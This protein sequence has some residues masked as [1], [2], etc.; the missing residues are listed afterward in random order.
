[1]PRTRFIP[2]QHGF[3]FRND[4]VNTILK[5]PRLETYGLCGGMALAALR[6]Y[7]NR[8]SVPT[9]TG[10]DFGGG[11]TVP[12]EGS[13]LRQFIYDNQMISY[14]PFNL[15]SAANWVTLPG[16]TFDTQ[17]GWSL[18]DEFP[19]IKQQLDATQQPI[20]LGLRGRREGDPFG[21]Q[22]L[23]IG[24]DENP[25]RVYLYD[26]NYPDVEMMICLDEARRRLV[27][28]RSDGSGANADLYASLFITGCPVPAE[29]PTY[30]DLGLQEGLTL[31]TASATPRVG[32]RLEVEVLVRNYGDYPA[33]V[34]Q[35]YVYVRDPMGNNRDDLLGGGDGDARPIPP[36]GERR[37]R[38][39]SERFGEVP[40]SYRIGVSY[41]SAQ[42]NWVSLPPAAGGTRSEVALDVLPASPPPT[43]GTW[44]SLGSV[45]TSPPAVGTN[46]DGRLQVFARGMDNR[47]WYLYHRA[48]N[49][50]NNCSGW[51]QLPG[52][53]TFR[54][55]VAVVKNNWQKLEIFG[56]GRD[57]AIWH[58]WQNEP[59]ARD[60]SHW[61][62]WSSLGQAAAGMQGDPTACLNWDNRIEVF[63][64]ASDNQVYHIWQRWFDAFGAPWSGWEALPGQRF[65][66]RVAAA[67]DA[68]GR[69]HVAAR[70]LDSSVWVNYQVTRG[71]GW[72]G[73]VPFNGQVQ[74]DVTLAKNIDGRLELFAHG[75]D[76]R[77]WH[78]WQTAP[79][80]NWSDWQPLNESS[81]PQAY[82]AASAGIVAAT[83]HSGQLEVFVR[84]G[85]G[86]L[87]NIHQMSG[88]PYWTNWAT[89]G[90][91]FTSD[92]AVGIDPNGTIEVFAL[93]GGRDL[94][95]QWF[96]R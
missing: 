80:G 56:L 37:I 90:A 12:P 61:S 21:H 10:A 78:R 43:V 36:G 82:L 14:G 41:L 9:H 59:N 55:P 24:Y 54:G 34:S 15:L 86:E 81:R 69:M 96:G 4:F 94:L 13:R 62:S 38:R 50:P 84:T 45:L 57:N 23:A 17:F 3:H 60:A 73:W 25:K 33:H 35:L 77:V 92:A 47:V 71:G 16:V 40:G 5:Y 44:Y 93:G 27:H 49:V 8:L 19:R 68:A 46:Q 31:R 11:L 22:V 70:A 63:A 6:Y 89:I 30:I 72:S 66:G 67:T 28:S 65:S 83:N 53:Q 20:V 39:V 76:N 91:G 79:N 18:K 51:E 95:H 29:R 85:S 88:F 42:G 7:I 75:M 87:M 2:S 64:V 58:R 52:D 74:G 1:M 48:A 26:S 32:E